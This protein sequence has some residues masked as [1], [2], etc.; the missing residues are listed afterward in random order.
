MKRTVIS[1]RETVKLSPSRELERWKVVDYMLDD[2]GP[3]K[4]EVKQSEFS[5]DKV[6]EDMEREEKGLK[7]V[8][9]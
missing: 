6:K 3:F 1:V 8:S 7:A 9:S 4:Y 5:W 2:F